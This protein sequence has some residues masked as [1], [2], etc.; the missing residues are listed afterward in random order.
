MWFTCK[1]TIKKIIHS[2]SLACSNALT[3]VFFSFLGRA[4]LSLY[5]QHTHVCQLVHTT[6]TCAH[7][8]T[9]T[10]T[11]A[12]TL[13]C[14]HTLVSW[15]VTSLLSVADQNKSP[16]CQPTAWSAAHGR[17]HCLCDSPEQLTS[18][19]SA[20]SL[21]RVGFGGHDMTWHDNPE[22]LTSSVSACSLCRVGFGGHDMTWLPRTTHSPPQRQ[23][24]ACQPV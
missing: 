7:T 22:Q 17:G 8:H 6:H 18:S 9:H 3:Q 1:K 20:C 2:L 13:T 21:C 5:T 11:H 23:P 12:H 16:K 4:R 19:V 24:A 10:H 14:K 15:S